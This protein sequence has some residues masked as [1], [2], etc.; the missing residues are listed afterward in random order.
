MRPDDA[1]T[2]EELACLARAGDGEALAELVE[3][4]LPLV[5]SLASRYKGS[6][7]REDLEQAGALGLIRAVSG[8]D[9]AYGTKL[10]TYAVP[11]ILGE[12]RKSARE[13]ASVLEQEPR[14]EGL[15]RTFD[16]L[17]AREL[18][19]SLEEGERELITLRYPE[20]L[21]QRETAKLLGVA[22]STVSRRE[23]R[24]LERLGK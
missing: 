9:P 14:D 2:N 23:K 17:F 16:R 1:G 22:Q 13:H 15:E 10:T 6:A 21:T 11:F 5:R 24:I 18:M 20:G 3:R 7:E 19:D 8:F 12:M 4:N